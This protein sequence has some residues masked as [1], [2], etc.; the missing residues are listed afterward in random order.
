MPR[1]VEIKARIAGVDALMAK[2][3]SLAD[4]GPWEVRQEDTY[5]GCATGRLKLRTG[6]AGAGELIYY[7]RDNQASPK[8]S[9]YQRIPTAD[10]TALRE[11]LRQALGQIGQVEK[12]RTV[13][14]RGRTRIH[15]DRVRGLG[16]FLELE[17]VLSDSEPLAEGITE[18]HEL[19]LQLDIGGS[20]LIEGSYLDLLAV[21][22]A[23]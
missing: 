10:P 1:N 5:F 3:R 21:P 14:L 15:L 23:S 9:V 22:Q 11:L 18:A 2:V 7:R 16:D 6:S 4:Q 8:E 13:F 20:Q 12:L 19:L 17:V